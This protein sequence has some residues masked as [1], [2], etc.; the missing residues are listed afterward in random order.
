MLNTCEVFSIPGAFLVQGD[1]FVFFSFLLL[2]FFDLKIISPQLHM[3]IYMVHSLCNIGYK[4]QAISY[5]P[6]DIDYA[7][8]RLHDE[9]FIYKYHTKTPVNQQRISFL[10]KTLVEPSVNFNL[11]FDFS[12]FFGFLILLIIWRNSLTLALNSAFLSY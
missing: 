2:L 5:R 6:F 4:T 12:G 11:I 8:Q 1:D 9:V 3:T 10:K 7:T